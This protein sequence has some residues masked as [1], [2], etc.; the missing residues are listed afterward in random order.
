MTGQARMWNFQEAM[1]SHAN[2]VAFLFENTFNNGLK[3][4]LNAKYTDAPRANYV[5]FG[6][7]TISNIQDGVLGSNLLTTDDEGQNPYTGYVEGRRT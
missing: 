7:S 6:G 4:T 5:D 3:W 1:D 2:E